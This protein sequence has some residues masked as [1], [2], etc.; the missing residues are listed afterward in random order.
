VS[1]SNLKWTPGAPVELLPGMVVRCGGSVRLVGDFTPPPVAATMLVDTT[2]YAQAIEP[3]ELSWLNN[4]GVP[5]K[6]IL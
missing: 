1:I 3:Y 2:E 6:V 4:M 5:A